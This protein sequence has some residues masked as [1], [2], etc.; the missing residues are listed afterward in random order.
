MVVNNSKMSQSHSTKQDKSSFQAEI[1]AHRMS[2]AI[3]I[4]SKVDEKVLVLW[5]LL[6]QLEKEPN[7]SSFSSFSIHKGVI[8]KTI[9]FLCVFF[10][11][12][13][14]VLVKYFEKN[15]E[16]NKLTRRISSRWPRNMLPTNTPPMELSTTGKPPW[17]QPLRRRA[18]EATEIFPIGRVC[19][20]SQYRMTRRYMQY[21]NLNL[22]LQ[23]RP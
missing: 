10:E 23:E 9:Y 21:S 7:S 4:G 5:I 18:T 22:P 2:G 16:N 20:G 19:H 8:R 13:L 6:I 3:H 1:S 15:S 17:S 12:K 14:F 11:E